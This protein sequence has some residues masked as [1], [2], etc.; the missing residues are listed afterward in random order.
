MAGQAA[1][2]S[3]LFS[4]L[5]LQRSCWQRGGGLCDTPRVTCVSGKFKRAEKSG[6][7]QRKGQSVVFKR[8]KVER[9]EHFCCDHWFLAAEKSSVLFD[10]GSVC[11][12]PTPRPRPHALVVC[13]S[14]CRAVTNA[15]L[16]VQ[17]GASRGILII[18]MYRT[19]G[20][21]IYAKK[22]PSEMLLVPARVG[23]IDKSCTACFLLE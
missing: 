6:F 8:H 15:H 22:S 5:T 17:I 21:A 3:T 14:C 7:T 2:D 23:L 19:A 16:S 20:V 12:S 11:N 18:S 1:R 10:S 13:C 4:L 9:D